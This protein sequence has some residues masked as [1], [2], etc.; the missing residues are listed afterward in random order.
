MSCYYSVFRNLIIFVIRTRKD[1]YWTRILTSFQSDEFDKKIY[2][3]SSGILKKTVCRLPSLR[4][5]NIWEEMNWTLYQIISFKCPIC[6]ILL[7]FESF[8][9]PALCSRQKKPT[10]SWSNST[11]VHTWINIMN[12]EVFLFFL[13]FSR[14]VN[15]HYFRWDTISVKWF[16][17]N[18]ALH[19][20]LLRII[21]V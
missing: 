17:F 3:D 19:L 20:L 16:A 10:R 5:T 9:I 15:V 13:L 2:F 14:F 6:T 11:S 12:F 8:V 18:L 1:T 21:G 4:V 7:L